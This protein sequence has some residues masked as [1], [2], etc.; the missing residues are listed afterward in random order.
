MSQ[1]NKKKPEKKYLY[2]VDLI[3]LENLDPP[4][5][6]RGYLTGAS[7]FSLLK[8][9][10]R[11]RDF[12]REEFMKEKGEAVQIASFVRWNDDGKL[13]TAPDLTGVEN[14]EDFLRVLDELEEV[15]AA[16]EESAPQAVPEAFQS[17]ESQMQ[18]FLSQ[19][20]GQSEGSD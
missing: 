4:I 10:I 2:L 18:Q 6:I 16:T 8:K 14:I 1:P 12:K 20:S 5:I 13:K 15:L 19:S 11:W 3:C 7:K 9:A 17:F